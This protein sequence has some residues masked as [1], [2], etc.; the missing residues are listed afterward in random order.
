M[1]DNKNIDLRFTIIKIILPGLDII[2]LSFMSI[3]YI[4]CS[5]EWQRNKNY[6]LTEFHR[7]EPEIAN[8]QTS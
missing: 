1:K 5:P 4:L 8:I 6:N 7:Q 3:V 2:F